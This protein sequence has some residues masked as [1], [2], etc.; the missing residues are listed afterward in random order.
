MFKLDETELSMKSKLYLD[1]VFSYFQFTLSK[2][3]RVY[4]LFH[5]MWS[6]VTKSMKF[7]KSSDVM[8]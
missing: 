4:I 3:S 6:E 7:R 8:R 1:F 2:S 5:F